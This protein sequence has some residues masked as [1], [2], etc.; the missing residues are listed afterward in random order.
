M[1]EVEEKRCQKEEE[2]A[3]KQ[4]AIQLQNDIRHTNKGKM[5]ATEH[6]TAKEKEDING[7]SEEEV[8]ETPVAVNSRGRQIRLPQRFRDTKN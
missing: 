6:T 2:K 8:E 5:K 1:Q 7:K 4:A 3:A